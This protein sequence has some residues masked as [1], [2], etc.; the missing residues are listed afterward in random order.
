M[1]TVED[2]YHKRRAMVKTSG[3][4]KYSIALGGKTLAV[5]EMGDPVP[6]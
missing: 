4:G 2:E 5:E 3:K 6:T 1:K